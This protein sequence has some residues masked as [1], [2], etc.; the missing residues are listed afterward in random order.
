YSFCTESSD[1]STVRA[2]ARQSQLLNGIEKILQLIE[3]KL[4]FHESTI[5]VVLWAAACAIWNN[6]STENLRYQTI[7]D[8]INIG[9]KIALPL[10]KWITTKSDKFHILTISASWLLCA[11]CRTCNEVRDII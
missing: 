5:S 11:L 3:N 4:V 6:V 1:I 7:A 2:T 9:K 8:C 10:W